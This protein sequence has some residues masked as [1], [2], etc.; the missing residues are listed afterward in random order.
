MGKMAILAEFLAIEIEEGEDATDYVSEIGDNEF[1]AEGSTYLVLTDEEA[2]EKAREYILDSLWAFN[3][4]FLASNTGLP[5]EVFTALQ[6]KCEDA[7][8]TFKTLIEK[9]GDLD[10]FVSEAISSDGRG[11]FMN[12]YDGQE[13]ELGDYYIYKMD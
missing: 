6:D 8:E 9:C 3:A 1:E 5:A 7:N 12:S 2:D 10:E 13:N 4:D 11:H